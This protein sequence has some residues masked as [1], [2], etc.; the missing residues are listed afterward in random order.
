MMKERAFRAFTVA[1]PSLAFSLIPTAIF[2]VAIGEWGSNLIW[3]RVFGFGW[4]LSQSFLGPMH[5]RL[6]AAIGIF[7]WPPLVAYALFLASG[8]L[9]RRVSRTIRNCCLIIL[10][11]TAAVIAPAHV[12]EARW[13][14]GS[15]PADFNALLTAY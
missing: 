14:P 1:I 4:F 2:G 3:G 12:I 10:L 15:V 9:Y 13:K 6:S 8:I 11:L 5:W 7:I